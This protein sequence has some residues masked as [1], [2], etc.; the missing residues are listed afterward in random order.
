MLVRDEIIKVA[1]NSGC[2]TWNPLVLIIFW[3]WWFCKGATRVSWTHN[4][5]TINIHGR[6]E[7]NLSTPSCVCSRG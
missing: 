4:V 3:W 1:R 6:K 2:V 7:S 5:S